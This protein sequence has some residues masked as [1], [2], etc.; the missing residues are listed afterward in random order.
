MS[1][2]EQTRQ[3]LQVYSTLLG[4]WKAENPIKTIKLQFLLATNAGLVGF[5]QINGGMISD[6][7]LL[8]LGGFV[9]CVIWTL[10]IGRTS[11]FQ[12][13]W[14]N[15]LDVI[16]HRYPADSRFQILDTR[17]AEDTAPGW[18]KI[19]GGVSSKYYLIGSPV[20]FAIGWLLAALT[21]I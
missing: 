10:S 9:L 14:K 3:D 13:V 20:L 15:K 21:V 11:L 7:L 8:M 5:I 17:Q 1:D 2:D 18:L 12:R 19:L 6:N 16:A 4:L